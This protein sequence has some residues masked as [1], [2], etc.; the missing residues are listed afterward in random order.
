MLLS[1][2]DNPQGLVVHNQ[3]MNI[4]HFHTDKYDSWLGLLQGKSSLPE[5]AEIPSDFCENQQM[6]TIL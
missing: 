5:A 1:T 4:L 6:Q 3:K 2:Q